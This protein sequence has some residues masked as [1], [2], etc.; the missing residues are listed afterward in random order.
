MKGILLAG[1]KGS[2][3]GPLTRATSKQLLPLYDKPLI[4]YPLS[5]LMLAGVQEV[6]LIAR[7][8]D[9][10]RL[11]DLFN[12][13]T[14]LGLRISYAEQQEPRGIAEALLIGESFL[15]GD[16]AAL[17]LG[18]NLFHGSGLGRS[19]ATISADNHGTILAYPVKDARPFAVVEID[20]EGRA[21]SLEEKPVSPK[22]HWA[23]PG[24]YF[25]PPDAPSLAADIRPSERGELEITDVNRVLLEQGRLDVRTLPRG[26]VWMDVGAPSALL[27]ASQ[28]VRTI[29]ERQGLVVSCPEEIALNNGW[30]TAREIKSRA[31]L[32]SGSLYGDYLA[33]LVRV[34]AD[35][36]RT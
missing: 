8:E 36:S 15:A 7:G 10:Q 30:I 21:L 32:F 18:D 26:S 12:D 25:L 20:P 35:S 24:L 33:E 28:Y 3:L 23:V 34:D 27:D 2:R 22:S 14:D 16:A 4:F 29:A 19:L 9:L 6:L 11:E 31:G 5:T 17:I 1:G 13:G